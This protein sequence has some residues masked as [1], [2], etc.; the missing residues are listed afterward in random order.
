MRDKADGNIIDHEF[1]IAINWNIQN[2]IYLIYGVDSFGIDS[3]GGIL[4]LQHEF[5]CLLAID[6]KFIIER[7]A[8]EVILL[9]LVSNKE[10][11]IMFLIILDSDGSVL[12]IAVPDLESVEF[13]V[14]RLHFKLHLMHPHSVD[15]VV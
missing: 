1:F 13:Q 2:R 10:D 5:E 8:I 14:V 3:D 15:D 7:L 4:G 6:C 12:L 11:E 9:V